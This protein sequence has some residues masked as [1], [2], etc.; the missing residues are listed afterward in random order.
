MNHADARDEVDDDVDNEEEVVAVDHLVVVGRLVWRVLRE[1][2]AENQ[3]QT[4]A[5]GLD[6]DLNVTR[7]GVGALVCIES[8]RTTVSGRNRHQ[9]HVDERGERRDRTHQQVR[10]RE[11]L[12]GSS[13]DHTNMLWNERDVN[14]DNKDPVENEVRLSHFVIG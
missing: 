10:R 13:P 1:I 14:T 9:V 12:T 2:D 8:H 5:Y 4:E 11:S 7:H 6:A 3:H